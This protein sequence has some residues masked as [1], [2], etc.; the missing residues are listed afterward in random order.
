MALIALDDDLWIVDHPHRMPGGLDLP[1]RMTVVR[2][3]DGTLWLHSPVPV[4][5]E[6][7]RALEALGPVAHVVAPSLM[8]D[9][10]TSSAMARWPQA[11]LWTSPALP[12][13]HPEWSV[14][15]TISEKAPDAWGGALQVHAIAGAPRV[16]E[17]V[18]HHAPSRTLIVTD[19]VFHLYD[20]PNLQS[21]L[22]RALIGAQDRFAVSRSWR[23]V[24]SKD[25]QAT[26]R[27][28]DPVLAWDFE[29][30]VMC[31]GRVLEAGGREALRQAA[32]RV[33]G[34]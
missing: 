30:V 14:T 17:V 18:F 20:P 29:R 19:L 7:A 23:W 26:R 2:L 10:F 15:G 24:F 4:D 1:T 27:S 21:R 11:S 25:R 22:M 13:R 8:H 3:P 16:D 5:D 6:T 34:P 32:D 33:L 12:E 9:L 31:H 28:L